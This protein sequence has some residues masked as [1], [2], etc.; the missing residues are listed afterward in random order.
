MFLS[1]ALARNPDDAALL[2]IHG[3]ALN[4]LGQGP[5]AEAA[6]R[7][8][9]GADPRLT[10]AYVQ[11]A[12]LLKAS[13]PREAERLLR[14]AVQTDPAN[15][16]PWV[17]LGSLY[18][19][20]GDVA[21]ALE[22]YRTALAR[23][24]QCVE[25]HF[26]HALLVLWSGDYSRGFEEYAWR[27]RLP[28]FRERQYRS[29][30]RALP[31][32]EGQHGQSVL[33]H[34]EQGLGDEILFASCIPDLVACSRQVV[35]D[36][37]ERLEGL[38]RR[39]FPSAR[40]HGTRFKF[41]PDWID[42]YDIDAVVP[43]GDLP[44]FF[45]NAK[46]RCPGLPYLD[47]QAIGATG[48]PPRIGIAWTGGTPSSGSAKRSLSLEAFLPILKSVQATWVCLEYKD[49]R[50]EIE[51]FRRAHGIEI[52]QPEEAKARDYEQTAA[53]VKGLDLVVSVTTAA[54]QLCGALGKECWVLVPA[55]P[56]WWYGMEGDT[57]CWYGSLKLFRQTTSWEG[58]ILEVARRLR[59]RYA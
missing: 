21:H 20:A 38:F 5:E 12:L 25:A 53:L 26:N 7:R 39:S 43:I 8:A 28:E 18:E 41:P 49:R 57:S 6:Y 50:S 29:R 45:R 4:A 2:F 22:C 3:N 48:R 17:N 40:V 42:D 47:A 46:A 14:V 52:H 27:W 10:D 44:R 54:V 35:I 19:A 24:P 55:L 1:E 59:R 58:P 51:A 9:I 34:G 23:D 31:K 37:D 36:C 11:L 15:A 13:D 32:W 56:R 33:V 16:I 30:G